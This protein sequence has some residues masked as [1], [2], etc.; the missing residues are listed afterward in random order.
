MYFIA[1]EFEAYLNAFTTDIDINEDNCRCKG[2]KNH[3]PN[4]AATKKATPQAKDTTF[5]ATF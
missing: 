4:A 2:P 1:L 3:W 5:T